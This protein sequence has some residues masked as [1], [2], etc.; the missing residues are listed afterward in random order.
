MG[1]V[2]LG[3]LNALDAV[4]LDAYGTLVGLEDPLPRLQAA[5]GVRAMQGDGP[6][7]DRG[8]VEQIAPVE[9]ALAA[10]QG[11]QGVDEPFLL[12]S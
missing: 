8:Q 12:F 5:F 1:V 6:P 7:G 11:E 3:R 10:G 2:G 9:S 4:T